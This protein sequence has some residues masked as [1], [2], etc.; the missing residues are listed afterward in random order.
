MDHIKWGRGGLDKGERFIDLQVLSDVTGGV[1][2]HSLRWETLEE[3]Q[4]C[5]E[6]LGVQFCKKGH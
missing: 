4:I 3:G 2:C 5:E 1:P 6:R